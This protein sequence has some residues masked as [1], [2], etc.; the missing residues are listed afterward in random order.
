M[1]IKLKSTVV[2][3]SGESVS[4]LSL[5]QIRSR[6]PPIL[7]MKIRQVRYK[8]SFYKLNSL[9]TYLEPQIRPNNS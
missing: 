7:I 8:T 6:N 4:M 2:G 3:F 9:E 5:I 1:K